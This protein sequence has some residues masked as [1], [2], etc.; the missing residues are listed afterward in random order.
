[1]QQFALPN[2]YILNGNKKQKTKNKIKINILDS[3]FVIVLY[4]QLKKV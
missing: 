3:S 2:V 1:M 4:K